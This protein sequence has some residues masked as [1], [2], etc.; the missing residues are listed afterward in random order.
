MEASGEI[1][2]EGHIEGQKV[3]RG[4]DSF[5]WCLLSL[6]PRIQALIHVSEPL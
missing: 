1:W 6:L 5:F 2:E 4:I 3:N